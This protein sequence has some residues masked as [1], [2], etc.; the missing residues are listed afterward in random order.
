M[1]DLIAF[2]G[3]E[4]VRKESAQS[5][6]WTRGIEARGSAGWHPAAKR[7][8]KRLAEAM[9]PRFSAQKARRK[10]RVRAAVPRKSGQSAEK[11]QLLGM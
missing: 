5:Y 1:C 6:V 2:G 3:R 4:E 8:C 7:I 9:W 10:R 11:W